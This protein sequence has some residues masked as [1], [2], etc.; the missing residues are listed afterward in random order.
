MK[1][2]KDLERA[3]KKILSIVK[4]G[5]KCSFIVCLMA[6]LILATYTTIGEI[7]AYYIGIALFKSSLYYI[8]GCIIFGFYF[9]KIR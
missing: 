4:N 9:N 8:V 7:S 6:C 1:F 3:D 5:L 2:I